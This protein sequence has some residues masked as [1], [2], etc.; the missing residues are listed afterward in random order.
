M[1][2]HTLRRQGMTPRRKTAVAGEK[3][4]HAGKAAKTARSGKSRPA[5]GKKAGQAKPGLTRENIVAAAL[6]VI[7]REG[8][9]E[10]SMRKLGRELGVNPMSIYY[11]FP[12]KMALTDALVEVVMSSIDLALDNPGRTPEKRLLTAA[13]IYRDA[14]LA[15]PSL[16]PAVACR[17]P[18]T[19]AGLRPVEVLIS[20]F[21]DAGFDPDDA[22]SSMNVLAAYVRGAVIREATEML[23]PHNPDEG[24]AD[25]APLFSTLSPQEYPNLLKVDPESKCLGSEAVFDRG[26]RALIRGLLETY[27]KKEE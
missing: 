25:M 11:H 2:N 5:G 9:D 21:A 20:I 3:E 1:A 4:A 15:Y 23:E 24:E 8:Y 22:F 18:R 27:G 10:L 7:D 19:P 16:L 12:N 6:A 14:M 17:A 26:A 13:Y